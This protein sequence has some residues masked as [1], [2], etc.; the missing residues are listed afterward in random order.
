MS[1]A[2]FPGLHATPAFRSIDQL[3]GEKARPPAFFAAL[4]E[5]DEHIADAETQAAEL[6]RLRDENA[7]L[8]NRIQELEDELDTLANTF[9]EAVA[10]ACGL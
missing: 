7:G 8:R 10:K 3:S 5:A 1:N 6:A 9:A 4:A 2:K